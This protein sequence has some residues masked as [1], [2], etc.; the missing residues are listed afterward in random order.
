MTIL[1]THILGVPMDCLDM[2]DAVTF[3]DHL[4]MT[5]GRGA[6][7]AVNPEKVMAARQSPDLLGALESAALLIPDGIGTVVAARLNGIKNVSRVAGAELMP[8]LCRLA[9]NKGYGVYL[10]GGRPE[11]NPMTARR[12]AELFPRLIIAGRHHGYIDD[13]RQNAALVAAINESKARILFVAVGSPRQELWIT[14]NIG[15]LTT[16]NVCQGVGGTFDVISGRVKRAPTTWRRAY[17]EWL[18]RVIREPS[19]LERM[20]SLFQ[21]AFGVGQSKLRSWIRGVFHLRL[22]R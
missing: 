6:I 4:V 16:V 22:G 21:F 9:E 20:P 12:L 2:A 14:R 10:F 1:R 5:G 15:K 7:I 8:E 17:L 3:A 11:V 19:R 13:E 18:Y